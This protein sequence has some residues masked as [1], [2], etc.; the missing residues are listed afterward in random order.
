MEQLE[1]CYKK[2]NDF[3][4]TKCSKSANFN[5]DLKRKPIFETMY[6]VK[7]HMTAL[8]INMRYLIPNH[9]GMLKNT[10]YIKKSAKP[11]T[12][13]VLLRIGISF[14]CALD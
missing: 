3:T 12:A 1:R 2:K 4:I 8:Y 5:F 7:E 9:I 11:L 13:C 14:R 10:S 6:E